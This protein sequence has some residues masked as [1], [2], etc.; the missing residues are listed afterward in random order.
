MQMKLL[1]KIMAE[2]DNWWVKI[3]NEKNLKNTHA[4]E[5]IKGNNTLWQWGTCGTKRN[6]QEMDYLKSG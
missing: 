5:Y 6:L 1:W 3:I 2:L 4:L